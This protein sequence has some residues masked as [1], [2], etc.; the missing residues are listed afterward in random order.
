MKKIKG[1]AFPKSVKTEKGG[2]GACITLKK[3]ERLGG[4]KYGT[5][6]PVSLNTRRIPGHYV[7]GKTGV[8]YFSLKGGEGHGGTD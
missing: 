7:A 8:K 1:A 4:K 6:K 2:D 3:D 5:S